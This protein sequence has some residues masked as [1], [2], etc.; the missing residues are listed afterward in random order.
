LERTG[1][2]SGGQARVSQ[3]ISKMP[4]ANLPLLLLAQDAV[5]SRLKGGSGF[6]S[7]T[8]FPD[9]AQQGERVT[10]KLTALQAAFDARVISLQAA[11][12]NEDPNLVLVIETVG[13]TADFA[14]AVAQTPGLE[15]LLGS[16]ASDISPDD[17]FYDIENS[18]KP[19]SGRLFLIGTNRNALREIVRLWQ[20]YKDNP[21]S[22]LGANQNAWKA[23]FEHLKD[24]RF[25]SAGDRLSLNLKQEWQARLG[26][27][28]QTVTF[29]IEAWCFASMDKND[30][31]SREIRALIL[32]IGGRVIT[33]CLIGEIAYH[34]FLVDVA[35]TGLTRLLADLPPRLVLSD[36]I[37]FFRPRGQALARPG[38]DR[39]VF[40]TQE[41]SAATVEGPPIVALLDGLPVENHPR[42]RGRLVV[43]DPAAT[44]AN[45]PVSE[46]NHGT[47]MASLIVWGEL[48][49]NEQPLTSPLYVRPILQPSDGIESS[50]DSQL[51]IDLVHI[52]VKRMFEGENGREPTA[53]TVK[54]INLSLGDIHRP[55]DGH[56]LSPWA[57]LTDWLS[58]K[59]NVL[60]VVSAGNVTDSLTL[61]V[62]R[63]TV[64]GVSAED[65]HRQALS[66]MLNDRGVRAI[67]S[68][69]ESINAITVGA[70][71]FDR[72]TFQAIDRRPVLF[73]D[74]GIAPYSC[75]GPGFRRAVKPDILMPGGRVRF[76]E[77]A[78]SPVNAS[79]MNGIW[80]TTRAPG[81]LV[82]APPV[83]PDSDTAYCRG[84]S[85]AAALGTRAAAHAYT[86]IERL[87]QAYPSKLDPKFDA[88]LLK[89]MLTHGAD[90]DGLDTGILALRPD[91]DSR[92]RQKRYV[93]RFLGFGKSNIQK[94]LECTEQRAT[95]IG[96]GTLK[97]EKSIV[98]RTPLPPSLNATA[99]RRRLTLT[100]AWLSPV[101]PRN[102]AY[103]VA[104]LW[105]ELGNNPLGT[106]RMHS[107]W[108]HA[109]LGTLQHEVMEGTNAVPIT[110]GQELT[111]VVNCVRDASRIVDPVAFALLVSL[112]VAEG[113]NIPIY[114]EIRDRV[115]P[116]IPVRA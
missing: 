51:L 46:R 32:E 83:G 65:R 98:F 61:D 88:V 26:Q 78:A 11:G 106:D 44:A 54:V 27:G 97:N 40:P 62:P 9:H 84:T 72:S 90:W 66:A 49:A 86:V 33:E 14:N 103:R 71:H 37:M 82:A 81:H 109:R 47:A 92:H 43:D 73:D 7:L 5:R 29:E 104:R 102:S 57:R 23:I 105:V 39:E 18:A 42:L 55:Y 22:D 36:R 76:E 99:E 110:D 89:A 111:F 94:S 58:S 113:V 91:I 25:W 12:P 48:D 31:A 101:N 80:K 38:D 70:T 41:F 95:L 10:Q 52:A 114:Q 63:D 93:S 69:A 35:A 50:P 20:V 8:H 17:D 53:P 56:E 4:S 28:E 60:F 34:G 107:E 19:L 108:R 16:M 45:Y 1:K 13:A 30:A 74:D 24:L 3:R 116:R 75:A 100:L 67:L 21:R 96:L 77:Y 64:A 85:N 6:S 59:Y 112:E 79:I 2:V 87:R 115:A 15:W 68:P